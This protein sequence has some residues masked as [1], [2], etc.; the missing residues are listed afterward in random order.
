MSIFSC[1]LILIDVSMFRS[2]SN[3]MFCVVLLRLDYIEDKKAL[4]FS[5]PVSFFL[6]FMAHNSEFFNL[7]II[8]NI[9]LLKWEL[10]QKGY[11]LVF[12][13]KQPRVE[14]LSGIAGY[15]TQY[16]QD[17][18]SFFDSSRGSDFSVLTPFLDWLSPHGHK[19]ICSCSQGLHPSRFNYN[20]K[21]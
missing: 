21:E 17:P 19:M 1:N 13:V 4:S 6:N 11:V 3:S 10:N 20:R 12:V 2:V 7:G 14:K 9:P 5:R 15:S 8:Q 16:L 18:L